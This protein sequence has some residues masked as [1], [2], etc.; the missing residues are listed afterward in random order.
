MKSI[1][2]IV[3]DHQDEEKDSFDLE[4]LNQKKL[5]E[6]QKFIRGK[7]INMEERNRCLLN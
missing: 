5:R 6:L 1:K 7:I 4:T 3:F 2:L